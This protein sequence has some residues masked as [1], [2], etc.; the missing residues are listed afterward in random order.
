MRYARCAARSS[1]VVLP[2]SATAIALAAR[3]NA[4]TKPNRVEDLVRRIVIFPTQNHEFG[5]DQNPPTLVSGFARAPFGLA[6]SAFLLPS[7]AGLAVRDG[8]SMNP[9]ALSLWV[10]SLPFPRVLGSGS[11]CS[12]ARGSALPSSALGARRGRVWLLRFPLFR[13]G[14]L[15]ATLPRLLPRLPSLC[16][17]ARWS[18]LALGSLNRLARRSGAVAGYAKGGFGSLGSPLSGFAPPA[19]RVL[20]S[21]SGHACSLLPGWDGFSLSLALGLG[22]VSSRVRL[23][24]PRLAQRGFRL[25]LGRRFPR[26]SRFRPRLSSV[27]KPPSVALAPNSRRSCVC[28]HSPPANQGTRFWASLIARNA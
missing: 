19:L 2:R 9:L 5:C 12:V 22:S 8:R 25:A 20:A 4:P 1:S 10:A 13:L 7:L 17:V 27:H 21:R 24:T 15:Y 26:R 28:Q 18:T 14:R 23:S 16:A 3:G 6:L 11:L